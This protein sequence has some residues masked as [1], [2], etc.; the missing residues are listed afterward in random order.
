MK[1]N[2]HHKK[3]LPRALVFSLLGAVL[4]LGGCASKP[5]APEDYAE[6]AF[7]SAVSGIGLDAPQEEKL[8]KLNKALDK[9]R[10]VFDEGYP[11]FYQGMTRIFQKPEFSKEN[12]MELMRTGWKLT[13]EGMGEVAVALGD[14]I[15]SLT[16]EQ[17]D[18][19]RE[20]LA[21]YF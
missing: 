1:H 6:H 14:F 21:E 20:K 19:L 17:R 13:G 18:K 4:A 16:A 15:S 8:K 7:N 5:L 10:E 12:M 11:D 9:V 3:H 2:M